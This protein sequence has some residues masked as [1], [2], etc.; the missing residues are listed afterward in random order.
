MAAV[1]ASL[2]VAALAAAATRTAGGQ[3]ADPAAGLAAA[4]P[5]AA[6]PLA[7][8]VPDRAVLYFGWAG[9]DPLA[10][11]YATSHLKALAGGIDP[12]RLSD[13]AVAEL[14]RHS[15]M[16]PVPNRD[17]TVAALRTAGPLAWRHPAAYY[18]TAEVPRTG[19]RP[20]THSAWVFAA[21]PD[22]DA[23]AA[24]L[25]DAGGTP[26]RVVGP[27]L[28]VAADD[29]R[30]FAPVERPLS[31]SPRFLAT[32]KPL[33]ATPAVAVY[34]DV[35]AV[36][37]AE[38]QTIAASPAGTAT[39]AK[40]RDALGLSAAQTYAYTAGFDAR[41][42]WATASFLA[43][44]GP[45]A[46][47]LAC[48]E[49]R[50]ADP[51]L[52]AHVPASA[53]SV[54]VYSL[55]LSKGLATIEAAAAATPATDKQSHQAI[56]VAS[57]GL[58]RNLRRQ[59][60]GP[61]GSQWV[62]YGDAAHDAA[63]LM[64][65]PTDP[66]VTADALTTAGYGLAGLV[67]AG[68]HDVPTTRPLVTPSQTRRVGVTVT[69]LTTPAAAPSYA[70]DGGLLYLC[71]T[72]DA[73]FAAAA[74]KPAAADVCHS[75]GFAAALHRL[76]DPPVMSFAYD[77]LPRTAP[78]AYA[79]LGR[80]IGDL[81]DVLTRLNTTLPDGPLPKLADVAPVLSPALRVG[82][83]DPAGV[84]T[85]SVE[86]FPGAA[87]LLG[88]PQLA[89]AV[90]DTTTAVLRIAA[91][92]QAAVVAVQ[93]EEDS[94]VREQLLLVTLTRWA[95]A[96]DGRFPPTLGAA[97]TDPAAVLRPDSKTAVPDGLTA[98]DR[99]AWVDAH[100][101][102]VYLAADQTGLGDPAVPVLAETRDAD[103]PDGQAIAFANG[104]CRHCD[105]ATAKAALA[106][107]PATPATKP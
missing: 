84:Y 60:L 28:V 31:A 87:A 99:P 52:L 38:D 35:A 20:V 65:R 42:D 48:V 66:A 96:H 105:E 75:P 71:P 98:A 34:A 86:P 83:A 74:V 97:V 30:A 40:V 16:G 67:N 46:G 49:P 54:A 68:V 51:A 4:G 61:L 79:K 47:L 103:R 73:A 102:Y 14:L 6:M 5:P 50:P 43:A 70:V 26:A 10:P 64:N 9:A 13:P 63:V 77:D 100:S 22:A 39:W 32:F 107:A 29:D 80:P 78:L 1:A 104:R 19:D 36:V 44:P 24:A 17:R 2:A 88:D 11:A 95:A 85:R 106:R 90:A 23:L 7:D 3:P 8:H 12:R 21:G 93:A 18:A 76:G 53:G 72:A 92:A 82:W 81:R 91:D 62:A 101:D 27:G 55:D 41:G 45:R 33:A 56:G 58:G 15:G 37:R 57:I 59:I 89:V 69:T 94:R 25:T